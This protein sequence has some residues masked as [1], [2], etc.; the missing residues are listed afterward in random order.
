MR[1]LF[2]FLVILIPGILAC[3]QNFNEL[4]NMQKFEGLF[5]FYYNETK[6]QVCLVVKEVD[7]EFLYVH[8]LSSGLGHNDIGLDRGQLGGEA[9]VFF[10]RAGNK[11]LLVQPNL[12]YRAVSDNEP[13]RKAVEQAFARSVL[14]GFDILDQ[15]NGKYLIDLKDML[16]ADTHRV[17]ERLSASNQGSFAL[18]HRRSAI[19]L[20]RTKAFPEN[21]EFD[22]LLTYAGKPEG[23]LVREVTPEAHSITVNQH[24]S[25]VKLPDETY[26]PRA[27]HPQSG[28][29]PM[30]YMDY[31][32]PVYESIRKQFITRHRLEKKDPGAVLSEA[33]EPI[34]YY[35]DNGTPEPVRT[36]LLEGGRWWNEAF[37]AIGFKDAFRVEILPEGADPMDVRYNMIQWVHRSTRGWSY[38]GF[39]VD[40][41]TGEIIKGHVSLGSLR[42]RQ[43]FKIA[44]ALV[45]KPY[46]TDN[47]NHQA[48]MDLALARIRQLSAHEIG[49]TLGFTHNFAAS[50]NNRSSVMDYPHPLLYVDQG[51]VKLDSAYTEGIGDWDKVTVA[52][53]YSIISK[54]EQEGLKRILDG[55]QEQGLRFIAD[56]DA[57]AAG[58]AHPEAHLWDNGKSATEELYKVLEIRKIAI[59]NF[60]MGNIREGESLSQL[61]DL[62]VPLYFF[63]RYQVEAVSKCIGGVSYSY[64]VKGDESPEPEALDADLQREALEAVLQTLSPAVLKIPEDKLAL[65]PPRAYGFYKSRE[66]FDGKTG[67]TFDYLA[68]PTAAANLTLGFLLHPERANRLVLQN[69]RDQNQLG[70]DELLQRLVRQTIHTLPSNKGYTEEVA[71]SVGFIVIDHL[72]KLASDTDATPQVKALTS[73]KLSE[74]KVWLENTENEG[75][76]PVYRK[77]FAEQISKNKVK[78]L[79]HLPSLPPGSPIGMECMDHSMHA[80]SVYGL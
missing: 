33:V 69:A 58:G 22:V 55:A 65:F 19:E 28:C 66:S 37:E 73:H 35:L 44:Q 70:L 31:A 62:F 6:D 7:K 29:I 40:P 15:E 2:L 80:Q 49:H 77:A 71:H 43:D 13:E 60:G 74:L 56:M 8:S 4:K 9:V 61:E 17:S 67:I 41:R 54:N 46:A 24:H 39:V 14:Y 36:A 45:N 68:P 76:D 18:D 12:R 47:K 10:R 5:D 52:Y 42:I 23:R 27:F 51:E 78:H 11:L 50:T 63:H 57:R 26:Q 72:I 1:R 48:M 38:G 64:A 3:S 25:F 21:V 59:R 32:S 53:A 30:S 16:Y 75:L 79:D 20:S 34:I